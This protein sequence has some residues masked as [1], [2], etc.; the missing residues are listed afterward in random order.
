MFILVQYISKLL[1]YVKESCKIQTIEL[2]LS[3][4][5][6]FRRHIGLWRRTCVESFRVDPSTHAVFLS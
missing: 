6:S 2:S 1:Q 3:K 4:T 5:A